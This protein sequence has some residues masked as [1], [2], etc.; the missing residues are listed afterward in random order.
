MRKLERGVLLALMLLVGMVSLVG[1]A[2][3]AEIRGRSADISLDVISR[4][5]PFESTSPAPKLVFVDIDEASLKDIGQWPWPR[6]QIAELID[7][8]NS[9]TPLVIGI[10]ILMLEAGR[11]TRENIASVTKI[12]PEKLENIVDGDALLGEVISRAPLVMASNLVHTIN[13]DL[14]YRPS[15]VATIGGGS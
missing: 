14:L 3:V 13:G 12:A 15:S 10:D 9:K 4:M 2:D 1:L 6:A 8:I 5:V 7:R 11:F